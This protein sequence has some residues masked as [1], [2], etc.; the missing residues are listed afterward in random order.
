MLLSLSLLLV[1][2]LPDLFGLSAL[3]L[4]LT[5]L[6]P[7]ASLLS[8]LLLLL[9]AFGLT[10]LVG[11]AALL[12]SLLFVVAALLFRLPS[13]LGFFVAPVVILILLRFS[14]LAA[15]ATIFAISRLLSVGKPGG[16]EQSGQG[17]G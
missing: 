17:E 15:Q 16:S 4:F 12:L 13:L 9:L 3:F 2:V 11:L 8:A 5:T 6:I 14:L 10:L 7:L 1:L